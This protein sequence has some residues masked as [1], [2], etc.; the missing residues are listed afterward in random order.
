[1]RKSDLK[2]IIRECIEEMGLYE[3]GGARVS[4][5]KRQDSNINHLAISDAGMSFDNSAKILYRHYK[6]S[7]SKRHKKFT[8]PAFGGENTK[9]SIRYNSLRLA[10]GSKKPKLPK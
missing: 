4:K 5:R 2:N 3:G 9:K 1:M 7:E 8:S 10:R 6:N